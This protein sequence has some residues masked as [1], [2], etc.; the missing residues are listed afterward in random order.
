MSELD[1]EDLRD[2]LIETAKEMVRRGKESERVHGRAN[3]E[4]LIYGALAAFSIEVA[5][6]LPVSRGYR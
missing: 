4:A 2:A 1:T 3:P 6:H 5:S